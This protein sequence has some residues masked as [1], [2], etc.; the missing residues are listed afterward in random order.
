MILQYSNL[1]FTRA[2]V[3]ILLPCFFVLAFVLN[4]ARH[5]S[6]LNIS[7]AE[8]SGDLW[9]LLVAEPVAVTLPVKENFAS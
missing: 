2:M 9:Q 1:F 3:H 8:T 6:G 7:G 4:L 5:E